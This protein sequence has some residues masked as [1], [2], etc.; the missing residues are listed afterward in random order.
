MTALS[1]PIHLITIKS[2]FQLESIETI[3]KK[4][5]VLTSIKARANFIENEIEKY[6]KIRNY[7]HKNV[8]IFINEILEY[9]EFE[10]LVIMNQ[11]L[12]SRFTS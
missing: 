4:L 6:M 3:D 7:W 1:K 8:P 12:N 11:M 9:L 2:N 10:K 5:N